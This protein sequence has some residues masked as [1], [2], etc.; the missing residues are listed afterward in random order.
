MT[1]MFS[2][3]MV[4]LMLVRWR[5]ILF[6][7]TNLVSALSSLISQGMKSKQKDLVVTL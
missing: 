4:V 7:R 1:L 3:M 6:A 2:L 5:I